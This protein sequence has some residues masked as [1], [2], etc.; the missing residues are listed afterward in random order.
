MDHSYLNSSFYN[1]RKNKVYSAFYIIGTALT[2]VFVVLL[3]QYHK[4]IATDTE[5]TVNTDRLFSYDLF[6]VILK[7]ERAAL[8]VNYAEFSLLE[9]YLTDKELLG[10]YYIEE[11]SVEIN[12]QYIP[13]IVN[14]VGGDY[15]NIY[16]FNF[17]EGRPFSEEE[18][19]AGE[20]KV[21]L[22]KGLAE[23]YFSSLKGCIGEKILVNNDEYTVVGIIDDYSKF[24]APDI[25]GN[26]WLPF[27]SAS[28]RMTVGVCV[29]FK[30]GTTEA[31]MKQQLSNAIQIMW[32]NRI[33]MK[34]DAE[35]FQTV[36]ER[37]LEE[38]GIG[39]LALGGVI[40]LL[41]LIPALNIVTLNMA[42]VYTRAGEIA[43]RRAIGSTKQAVFFQ[44]MIEIFILVLIG[45]ALGIV[46]A[47]PVVNGIQNFLLGSASQAE[48]S[49][50]TSLDYSVI[51]LQVIP[52]AVIFAFL[53]GGIPI[54]TITCKNI[55]DMLKGEEDK[56]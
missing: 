10:L 4:I 16:R 7:N 31:A 26:I 38:A 45:L 36:K 37:K 32:E 17:I 15:F 54:Y 12:E 44:Q 22:K 5:P 23:R 43:V 52:L 3:L 56:Q 21:I 11:F 1:I 42:N 8:P 51:F 18:L 49:L 41:L 27:G 48:M 55:A 47:L 20:R 34:V 33:E 50:M 39:S 35:H 6:P 25:E 40:V 24:A 29:L 46:C 9:K 2:F 28:R 13:A 53:S 19:E 14:V 30:S